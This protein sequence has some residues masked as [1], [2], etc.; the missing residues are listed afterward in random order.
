MI[1]GAALEQQNQ[2]LV[3][4]RQV[5]R[6]GRFSLPPVVEINVGHVQEVGVFM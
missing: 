3:L 6:F 2:P 5:E 1:S 4:P